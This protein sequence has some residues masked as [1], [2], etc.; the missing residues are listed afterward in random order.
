VQPTGQ[1]LGTSLTNQFIGPGATNLDFSVFRA[2]PLGGNR[3]L[4]IRFE[5][6]NVLNRPK[7]DNPNASLNYDTFNAD[8]TAVDP[9]FM[10]IDDTVGD[11]RQARVA[12]RFSY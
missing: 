10:V 4:E 5:A 2:I 12:F 11:M 6:S 7:W 8:R 9:D 3:R 1:R